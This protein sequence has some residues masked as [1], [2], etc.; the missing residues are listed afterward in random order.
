MWTCK[1]CGERHEDQFEDCWKCAGA[2][3]AGQIPFP[4]SEDPAVID[5][6]V[7]S[8]Q[9]QRC[10]HAEALIRR[11]V[12][13]PSRS[14]GS[15]DDETCFFLAVSCR[16]CGITDFYDAEIIGVIKPRRSLLGVLWLLGGD[17]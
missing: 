11:T 9:C 13:G 14:G 10:G 2:G 15:G 5:R 1:T 8:F 17:E 7:Q 12:T 4:R 6:I 16:G 3:R